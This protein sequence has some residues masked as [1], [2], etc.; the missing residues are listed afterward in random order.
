MELK[1]GTS[2][3]RGAVRDMTDREVYLN[4][5]GFLRWLLDSDAIRPGGIVALGEDLRAVDPST[6]MSSSP[7]IGSAVTAAV[8]DLGLEPVHCGRIPTPTLA[9]WAL[10][11]SAPAIMV[12]GS[13][14]PADRNGI[15]FYKPDGEVLKSDEAAI[16]AA[17]R[18]AR[19]T[20]DESR[21]DRS[22]AFI[23]P[24]SAA[25][26][27]PHAAKA[28]VRR[29]LEPFAG[30]L[31]LKGR[32]VVVWQHSAAG[33]DLLVQILEG[34]GAQVVPV[35]RSDTFVAVDTEDIGPEEIERFRALIEA[36]RPHALVSTDGDG[37]RPLVVDER[38]RFHRGDVVGLVTA[39]FLGAGFAAVPI[40]TT[41]ALD[42][43]LASRPDPFEL[44]KTRIGSP[45][46]IAAMEDAV[47]RGRR[48]VVGWEVN[49]GFLT[50][51]DLPLGNG[52]IT[53]LPTRDAVLPILAVLLAAAR[54]GVAV[55]A[56]FDAL[57]PRATSAGLVDGVFPDVG[58]AL[59]GAL[60]EPFGL[61]ALGRDFPTDPVEGVDT[62]D[63]VRIRFESG[64]V[65]HFRQSGNA[66]QF[67]CYA[68][69][70][71][72]ERADAIVAQAVREPDGLVR[73]LERE[74]AGRTLNLLDLRTGVDGSRGPRQVL[75][76]TNGGDGPVVSA[77]L[78]N[79]ASAI[80]RSDGATTV[81]VHEEV[82]RRGQFLGLLDAVRGWRADGLQPDGIALGIMLPG[83]GTRL[84]PLTQ[85]LHGI[86][87]FMPVPVRTSEEGPWLDGATASLF[88]WG[89]VVR[90][91]ER[92]GFGGIAWKWGDEPI[93]PARVLAHLDADLSAAD[94]IRF[95]A[96][97]PVTEEMALN[98]E[99]LVRDVRTCALRLQLRRR[100]LPELRARISE[101]G[102]VEALAHLGS[103]A[104]SWTLVEEAESVFGDLSGWLDVDGYLFEA[105]THDS[106]AW[107]REV[108]RDA[109][110]RGL[111][112]RHP[113]FYHRVQTLRQRIEARR[114]QKMVVRVIDLGEGLYWGDI[115][116]L[117]KARGAWALLAGSGAEGR[118]AR[119]LAAMQ[120]V[121]SDR[122]GN[123]V[124]GRAVVPTDGSVRDSVVVDTVVHGQARVEGAVLVDCELGDAVVERGAVA[125]DCVARRL[126][127]GEG[128][129]AFRSIGAA[130]A[131]PAGRVHTSIPTDPADPEG[132]LEDWWADVHADPGQ[133]EMWNEPRFGNPT[134]FAAK[135][136]QMRGRSV[137]PDASE[138]A[139]RRLHRDPLVE[140]L[141]AS[142]QDR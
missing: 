35:G 18:W 85:R 117:D 89:L 61:Q 94:A 77:A 80:F 66:P 136:E 125:L 62:T 134:S 45:W 42:R 57:P 105:L 109:G 95:G 127:V 119:Q 70:D 33:R 137:L 52:V 128:G 34:L 101:L 114:G 56:L 112:A 41:D 79:F 11:R 6:G 58:R 110:L 116:Q 84:S 10:G 28:Y 99:W 107:E 120:Q 63:G 123:R 92:L 124:V 81:R 91:L 118:F 60:A 8:R 23:R 132:G 88:T 93:V 130:V 102:D 141:R 142:S 14:V 115:G 72:Q 49:G 131:V 113:D 74:L 75:A 138:A 4:A 104:L 135:F 31:P 5:L 97:V 51:T 1:F 73:R 24:P 47:R 139:L 36:H 9:S 87:P 25:P 71:T 22:G 86:K 111:L 96:R 32:K 12:T 2:G 59:V 3:L 100:P 53:A 122:F 98:K 29:Y 44:V 106:A 67:R 38:G 15:K 26:F 140:A 27:I 13:H 39:E 16:R 69:S 103:P 20:V 126:E 82:R 48:A 54:R 68:V 50:A 90:H 55:S 37:D 64:D 43:H 40:S 78:H 76:I 21:F 83:K 133:P 121:P 17:V 7:R 65:V 30:G 19:A 129:F 108:A 46:V